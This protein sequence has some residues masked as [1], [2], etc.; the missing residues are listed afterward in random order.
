M[1]QRRTKMKNYKLTLFVILS[2]T[3]SFLYSDYAKLPLE[4]TSPLLKT[5]KKEE[6]FK[7]ENKKKQKIKDLNKSKVIDNQDLKAELTDLENEFKAQRNQLR[8]TYKRKR[9]EIYKKYG[10]K[11]PQKNRSDAKAKDL[12]LKNKK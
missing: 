3:F 1:I 4:N 8:E 11:P 7:L 5:K 6:K 12:K 2:M 10:V 9:I